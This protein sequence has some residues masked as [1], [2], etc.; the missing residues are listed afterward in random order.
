LASL[1]LVIQLLLPL[2]HLLYKGNTSWT[3]QGNRFAWRMKVHKKSPS[4]QYY[5]QLSKEDEPQPA[6]IG[7]IIN[8]MQ[9]YMLGEDP[10]ML[11]QLA[12]YLGNDLKKAGYPDAIITVSAKVSLNSRN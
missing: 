2:R 7:I 1:Y 10:S 6:D 5:F 8:T 12:D 3:G 11:L 9:Q 4:I